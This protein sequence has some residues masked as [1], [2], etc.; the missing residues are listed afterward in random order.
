MNTSRALHRQPLQSS[1]SVFLYT[2][3]FGFRGFLVLHQAE[4]MG[5]SSGVNVSGMVN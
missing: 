5:R 3:R 1:L 4:S 2:V